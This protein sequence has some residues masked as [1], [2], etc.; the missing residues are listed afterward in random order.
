MR[1]PYLKAIGWIATA[2]FLALLSSGLGGSPAFSQE[3]TPPPDQKVAEELKGADEKAL[4]IFLDKI[5]IRG[6]IE[7]PQTV[8]IVPGIDPKVD[9]IVI[10][11][12]FVDIITRPLDKEAFERK[13]RMLKA[14]IP[15]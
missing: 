2:L 11:R 10:D 9:D 3:K 1:A 8:Y 4:Q 13:R 6:W 14:T 12:T 15:W 5:E 7:K